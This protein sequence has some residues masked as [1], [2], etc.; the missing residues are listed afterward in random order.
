MPEEFDAIA[1]LTDDNTP[2]GEGE[3][4]PAGEGSG[5]G[6][7]GTPAGAGAE[8]A[9]AGE[10]KPE[11]GEGE[12]TPAE[13]MP[14]AKEPLTPEQLAQGYEELKGAWEKNYPVLL[15]L[16]R[17]TQ[18]TPE[19]RELADQAARQ[20]LLG[21]A[22]A[23]GLSPEQLVGVLYKGET[24][25]AKEG[26]SAGQEEEFVVPKM[27]K[28][29]D[30]MTQADFESWMQEGYRKMA[31]QLAGQN[32]A[33]LEPLTKEV[34]QKQQAT[35]FA[36]KVEAAYPKVSA[37]ILQ[38]SGGFKPTPEQVAKAMRAYPSLAPLEATQL[39]Y[40]KEIAAQ[41]QKASGPKDGKTA[42]E[43]QAGGMRK[44]VGAASFVTDPVAAAIGHLTGGSTG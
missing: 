15:L 44:E 42:P 41:A 19:D 28:E 21:I 8:G 32:K 40:R 10:G 14:E 25:P 6:E 1:F 23:R 3:G 2:A 18:A 33:Q 38:E 20:I 12:E 16:D 29:F 34:E 39:V 37:A 7:A 4:A 24:P 30:D 31:R 22:Q 11:D 35:E 13:D 17:A 9:P 36:K 26:E 43:S 5:A 27:P